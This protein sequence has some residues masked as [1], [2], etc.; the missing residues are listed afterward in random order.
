MRLLD[1]VYAWDDLE[2]EHLAA[3]AAWIASGVPVHR[4]RKPNVPSQHLVSYFVVLDEIRSQLL[5]VAHRKAGLW[6]PSGGHLE[7]GEDPWD[8]VERECWEE[9]RIPAVPSPLIGDGPFFVTMARTRGQGQHTDVS[10]W[11]VLQAHPD[12][13]TWYD[14][15]EFNEIRWL[16]PQ[17]ILDEPATAFDPHMHR[18]TRKLVSN[19]SIRAD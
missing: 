13:V 7:P 16:T 9:L 17:Q 11:Y 8:T 4:T 2:R 3:A 10:L 19:L 15:E 14:D 5:L 12:S 6:L 18:F 1:G